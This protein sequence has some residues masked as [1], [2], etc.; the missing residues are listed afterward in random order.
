MA[1]R[2]GRYFISRNPWVIPAITRVHR[3]FYQRLG[4]RF[5]ASAGGSKIL[6]LTTLGRHSGEARVSPLLY[7]DERESVVIVASNGG[8]EKIPGWWFNLQADPKAHVQCGTE[9]FD[10]VAREANDG[11]VERLWA[12][13]LVS[14]EFFDDYQERTERKIPVILL[15]RV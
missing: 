5:G 11:E 9:R 2:G 14:Y 13:L 8:Q 3:W 7:I 10:V 15:E 12:K 6:L 1:Q 4:G